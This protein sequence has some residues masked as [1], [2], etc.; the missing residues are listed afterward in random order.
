MD[1]KLFS[2]SRL[3][4]VTIINN[5]FL[6]LIM[7][8]SMSVLLVLAILFLSLVLSQQ[9]SAVDTIALTDGWHEFVTNSTFSGEQ[10]FIYGS[11]DAMSQDDNDGTL[12]IKHDDDIILVGFGKCTT[13]DLYTYCF[14]NKSFENDK[15][16][17][18]PGISL[19]P[20][21]E[22][23]ITKIDYSSQLSISKSFSTTTPHINDV[24]EA[25]T[26]ITNTGN[27]ALSSISFE[28]VLPRGFVFSSYDR[29][30]L[31]S[32]DKLVAT[33]YSIKPGESWSVTYDLIAKEKLDVTQRSVSS[34]DFSVPELSSNINEVEYEEFNVQT[35]FTY[36]VKL[37]SGS[38]SRTSPVDYS[39]SISNNEERDLPL[40]FEFNLPGDLEFTSY[41]NLSRSGNVFSFDD[42]IKSKESLSF[43]VSFLTPFSGDYDLSFDGFIVVDEFTFP[44]KD[45]SKLNVNAKGL[46]CSLTCDQTIL[47]AGEDQFCDISITNPSENAYYNIEGLFST[48]KKITNL[49]LVSIA[50]GKTRFLYNETISTDSFVSSQRYEVLFNAT[51]ETSRKEKFTCYSSQFFTMKK[52]STSMFGSKDKD[53]DSGSNKGSSSKTISKNEVKKMTFVE[54]LQYLLSSIFG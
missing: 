27:T 13:K 21:L 14:I 16:T 43:T 6:C 22:Y 1:N 38:V 25:T 37:S 47:Y 50:P 12:F 31:L 51:F 34:V 30:L 10:Y 2:V 41:D 26:T 3:L 53:E 11:A 9:V 46:V 35:P 28:E 5:L 23:S 7:K 32:G 19:L 29:D 40:S 48:P 33:I 39:F 44:L 42:V 4:S 54:K 15:I 52:K 36:D 17:P 45:S 8:R 18:G 49:S 24:V 20:A